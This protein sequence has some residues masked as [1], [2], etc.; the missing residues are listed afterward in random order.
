M[1][2]H[3]SFVGAHEAK[4]KVF[5]YIILIFSVLIIIAEST[6]Y[7]PKSDLHEKRHSMFELAKEN[8]LKRGY[9]VSCFETAADAAAYLDG[10]I[11][12]K[13]V[14]FGG[15][16]TLRTMGLYDTLGS[17][18]QVSWQWLGNARQKALESQVFICSVNAAAEKSKMFASKKK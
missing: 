17:H 10:A 14:G 13:T 8:L 16:M 4:I 9:T 3:P 5:L 12:G 18:N 2:M 1:T 7:I 11:D 15:S 6:L